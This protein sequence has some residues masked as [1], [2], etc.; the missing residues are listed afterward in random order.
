MR[1]SYLLSVLAASTV[2]ASPIDQSLYEEPTGLDARAFLGLSAEEAAIKDLG[3]VVDSAEADL[4]KTPAVKPP[5]EPAPVAQPK[6]APALAAIG[7]PAPKAPAATPGPA[8]AAAIPNVDTTQFTAAIEANPGLQPGFAWFRL[9]WPL[10]AEVGDGDAESDSELQQLRQQLGFE[11]IGIVMGQVTVNPTGRGKNQK[12]NRDF[13]AQLF[14]MVS[15]EAGAAR[16]AFHN[17]AVI[18]PQVLKFGGVTTAAK[19]AKAK[20]AAQ[21]HVAA[22][23]A[24]S[25]QTNNCNTFA[26]AMIAQL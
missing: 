22:N 4:K 12:V 20:T 2:I 10:P 14:H 3:K 1:F 17:W 26:N 23:P 6:K 11:H 21:A 7:T 5:T 25:V 16:V 8:T 13:N 18:P 15:N 19:I 9:E 24:Y